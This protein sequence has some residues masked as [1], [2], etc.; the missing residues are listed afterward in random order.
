MLNNN[1]EEKERGG[2]KGKTLKKRG[3]PGFQP[4]NSVGEKKKK[5]GCT[6][7]TP[8]VK[9]K[10]KSSRATGPKDLERGK[11]CRKKPRDWKKKNSDVEIKLIGKGKKTNRKPIVKRNGGGGFPW[12]TR[13][14]I[15]KGKRKKKASD[16]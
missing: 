11:G 13:E 4:E 6:G 7:G 2:R 14:T 12:N 8:G 5:N 15:Q 10:E 16:A 9:E 1:K 3:G